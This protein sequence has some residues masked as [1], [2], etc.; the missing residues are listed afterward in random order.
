VTTR[1]LPN[2]PKPRHWPPRL[3]LIVAT[4]LAV[5]GGGA[6]FSSPA[7]AQT[8]PAGSVYQRGAEADSAGS[9]DR[10]VAAA[11]AALSRADSISARVR[12]L[13]RVGDVVLKGGGRYVQSGTGSD[14]RFRLE[15][16]LSADTENFDLLEVCDG[17]FLWNY[18]QLGMQP[19]TV[20]RID[21][22]RVREQLERLNVGERP[23]DGPYL[24]GIQR[25]LTLIRERF[26]FAKPVAEELDGMPVWRMEGSW[27]KGQ[28]AALLPDKAEAINGPAG[29][30]AA[31]LPEGLPWSVRLSVGRRDLFPFRVEWLAIPG[32]RP[33]AASTPD[34]V[35]VLEL[36]DVRIGEPV[37]A[38]A[39]VYK[40]AIE[41]LVDITEQFLRTLRPMRP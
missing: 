21:V 8:G 23:S 18:R 14:Q 11:I 19:A 38:T 22:Q 37:D 3:P 1:P 41:G 25:M 4:A 9:G 7:F 35:T 28:L 24:G 33:V 20:Q 39:F 34:V 32:P 29:I 15:S 10:V 27:N 5:Q 36:Y 16:R 40:P 26:E 31:D 6:G 17:L 2:P 30:S 12:Q 13:S